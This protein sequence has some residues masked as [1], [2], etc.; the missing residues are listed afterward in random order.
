MSA[1]QDIA[2]APK[3]QPVLVFCPDACEPHVCIARLDDWISTANGATTAE[4]S[5]FWDEQGL[6]VE[7]LFW[8]PL[9]EPPHSPG[10]AR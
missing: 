7:P 10:G 5:D 8:Q 1:W 6:D 9:P 3:G 4:W 2:T